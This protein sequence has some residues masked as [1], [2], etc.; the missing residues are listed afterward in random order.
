MPPDAPTRISMAGSRSPPSATSIRRSLRP[1]ASRPGM[2]M[3]C[4]SAHPSRVRAE[5]LEALASIAP[6]GL[7]RYL[8]GDLRSHGQ[9]DRHRHRPHAQAGRRVHHLLGQLFRALGR[10]GRASPARRAIGRRWA[11]QQHAHVV[12]FRIP[13]AWASAQ[14]TS[15]SRRSKRLPRPGRRRGADRGDHP[16]ADPGQ[17]RRRHSAGG[18]PAPAAQALQPSRCASDRRRDPVRLR[19]HGAHVGGRAWQASRPT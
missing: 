5:F 3:H 15:R 16:G 12:P 18:F 11:C 10:N 2:L 7:D 1:C 8:A 9:R 4:P 13:C 19:A 6:T 17:W 14:P